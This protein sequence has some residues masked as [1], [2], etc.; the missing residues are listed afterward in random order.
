MFDSYARL[1]FYKKQNAPNNISSWGFTT[2]ELV[3]VII[4]IGVLAV[5][6]MPRLITQQSVQANRYQ[7]ELISVLRLAQWQQMNRKDLNDCLKLSISKYSLRPSA[8]CTLQP[9]GLTI[10]IPSAEQTMVSFASDS[11]TIQFN[12]QGQP[13]AACSSGCSITISDSGGSEQVHINAEGYIYAE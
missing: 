1:I 12:Q 2:I 10:T 6:A 8:S 7:M 5:T 3:V 13:I 4:L 9:N 11:A